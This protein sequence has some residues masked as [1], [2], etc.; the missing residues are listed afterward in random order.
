MKRIKSC[1]RVRRDPL[2]KGKMP[3]L[4]LKAKKERRENLAKRKFKKTLTKDTSAG[5]LLQI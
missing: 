1:W 2:K 3:G 5:F 4:E